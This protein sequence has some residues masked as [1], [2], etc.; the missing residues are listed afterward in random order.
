M[1]PCHGNSISTVTENIAEL[2]QISANKFEL[3]EEIAN[4]FEMSHDINSHNN[5]F[6]ITN[7]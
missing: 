3:P 2:E 1:T 7:I 4:I 6:K 5:F